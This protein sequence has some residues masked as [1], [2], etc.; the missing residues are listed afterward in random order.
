MPNPSGAGTIAGNGG[1]GYAKITW[2]GVSPTV[3]KVDYI[4]QGDLWAPV[5]ATLSLSRPATVI[6]NGW[7]ERKVVGG[8]WTK[9]NAP[10]APLSALQLMSVNEEAEVADAL[11]DA[12]GTEEASSLW[13]KSFSE[14]GSEEVEF[15]DELELTGSAN[16]LIQG[17][18]DPTTLAVITYSTTENTVEPII[19][20]VN[21]QST[22]MVLSA[23]WQVVEPGTLGCP[24]QEAT[25]TLALEGVCWQ[26]ALTGNVTEDVDWQIG[27]ET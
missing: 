25:G 27:A 11:A 21:L 5:M 1:N 10:V 24:L 6:T 4:R 22:G 26:K 16:V 20:T 17:I 15:V 23:G 9:V 8:V 3:A 2:V 7:T 12:V 13:L 14:N 19:A 18:V